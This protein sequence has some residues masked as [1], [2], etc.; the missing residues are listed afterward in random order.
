MDTRNKGVV[1]IAL[2]FAL[3]LPVAAFAQSFGAGAG[4][5]A[6]NLAGLG[7]GPDAGVE[8]TGRIY[9]R[10]VQ[11]TSDT[12]MIQGQI[13]RDVYAMTLIPHPMARLEVIAVGKAEDES[14]GSTQREFYR[15]LT[16]KKVRIITDSALRDQLAG[17]VGYGSPLDF[18]GWVTGE[19]SPMVMVRDILPPTE[20]VRVTKTQRPAEQAQ[21]TQPPAS[22][23]LA[24]KK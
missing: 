15:V 13:G 14:L 6:P 24:S 2:A 23:E 7:S 19:A 21:A 1:G 12:P 3:L 17:L 22:P 18:C 20:D 9:P 8:V 4:A 11:P 16:H 5:A 10:G